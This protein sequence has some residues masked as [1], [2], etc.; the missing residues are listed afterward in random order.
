MKQ[1]FRLSMLSF[2]MLS[3]SSCSDDDKKGKAI[4]ITVTNAR[5][6]SGD[7]FAIDVTEGSTMQLTAFIMPESASAGTVRY[8]IHGTSSGAIS[9][10]ESGLI[11][12]LLSIPP[13]GDIPLPLGTDVIIA[14]VQDGSGACV[15]YL[16]RVISATAL[17][18]SI[19]IQSTGQSI[20]LEKNKTFDLSKYVTIN[21]PDATDR[22]VSYSSENAN[23]A[24]VDQAGLITA[25]GTA[26]QTTRVTVKSNDRKGLS[27]VC[28]VTIGA[29]ANN[30]NLLSNKKRR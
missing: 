20:N 19:T 29:E 7:I 3:L 9:I 5:N 27:A 12:P 4:N 6:I 10:S 16:V 18:T 26:G 14:E 11:T 22:T 25:V 17:V 8:S 15:R 21:P 23:I 28:Y 30:R 2:I 24:A 13:T 1:I